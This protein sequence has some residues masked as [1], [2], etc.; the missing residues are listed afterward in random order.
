MK[1]NDFPIGFIGCGN[2]ARAIIGA[3]YEKGYRELVAS[4]PDAAQLERVSGMAKAAP[5]NQAVVSQSKYIFLCIKPQ[6]AESVLAP[7]VFSPDKI[8]IS[9]MA[10]IPLQKIRALT[11]SEKAVRV[12]PNLNA[13]VKQ[14]HN[15][16]CFLNPTKTELGA[17]KR[18]LNAF[19]HACE[20]DESLFSAVT[21]ISGS[22]PAY[23]FRFYK[24]LLMAAERNGVPSGDALIMCQ[25][26]LS[27]SLI[28]ALE[29][30]LRPRGESA[31][32]FAEAIAALDE[33]VN[34]ICSPKG[35]TI[36]AV[37]YLD[38]QGFSETVAE[39]A[40]RAIKRAGELS[41]R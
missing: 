29:E 18:L 2:M 1:K 39:A 15:A 7:L 5:D 37:E 36:E 16:Y 25:E 23:V 26:M 30:V 32:T 10:G 22:G 21:G 24:G 28:T 27:G 20:T 13:A 14:S 17:V 31:P 33:K 3:L 4:D 9:I 11:K 35:T 6:A 41:G 12:M 38:G 34:S 8:P 19:G 40:T